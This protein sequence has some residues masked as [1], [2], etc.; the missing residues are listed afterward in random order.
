MEAAS[1]H[2]NIIFSTPALKQLIIN[3]TERRKRLIVHV[4]ELER[5]VAESGGKMNYGS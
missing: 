5:T 1:H 2:Q 4:V 3:K